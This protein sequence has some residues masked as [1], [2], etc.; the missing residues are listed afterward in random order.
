MRLKSVTIKNFRCYKNETTIEFDD[1]TALIGR[2]DIGKSTI[3]EAL[4]IFFNNDIVKIDQTDPSV[5]SESMVVTLSCD[6]TNLPQKLVL[7]SGEETDLQSEYLTVDEDTLRVKK[8][9]DCSKKNPS[10]EIFIV[11]NHPTAAGYENLLSIKERDLQKIISEKKIDSKLKGN[12]QMR[13]AIWGSCDDLALAERD[14]SVTKAKE[15][16]KSIWDKLDSYLPA[17]ALF[18]CDRSSKDSDDEVQDPMKAAII[19]AI[20]ETQ[21]EIDQIQEKIKQKAMDI[22]KATHAALDK[23]DSHLATHLS[24]RF[25]TPTMSKWTG[26]FNIAMDTDNGIALNKRGSGVRRLVLVSFFMAEADRRS[27]T[28]NK[29]DIIYAIEEPETAQH[30]KNQKILIDSF[31]ELSHSDNT[32]IL[33]TTH[34]PNLAKELP[35]NSLRFVTKEN[36]SPVV[37]RGTDDV[38]QEIVNDMGI[39]ATPSKDVRVVLCVEGPTDVIAMKVFS[40]CLREKHPIVV[41][42]ETDP[43]ISIIPLGGSILKYWVERNYLK[44][45]GVKEIHI[46]DRDVKKYQESIDSVN[47]RG[48]GSW[49]TLTKK[50]EIENYLHP[51]AIKEVYG[52]EIDTSRQGVPKIF[53]VA[54]S[55][56]NHLDAAMKDNRAKQYLSKAF[57]EGM[58]YERLVA[59]D[60]DGE[61]KGWFDK[62]SEAIA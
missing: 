7:D 14:I 32:Q 60:T 13:K 30:P 28:S 57:A 47:A 15:D 19:E 51:D 37:K 10:V 36:D 25:S 58:T 53:G 24:P 4:E 55:E 29:R 48:D 44:K 8:V 41:D 50:Y 18:Q 27:K 46:Y 61:V 9:F 59:V 31:I 43:R 5:G 34:S 1:L 52:V 3:L 40:R 6:F 42:L 17:F 26:L 54:Y 2:N 56:K 20:K 39:F 11:A 12:P 62:I 33:L 23:I 38:F 35:V 49:G 45:L 21:E 16:S 22:A